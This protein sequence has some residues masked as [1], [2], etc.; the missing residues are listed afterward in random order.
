MERAVE[1][2]RQEHRAAEAATLRFE[3]DPGEQLQIDFG[4]KWI[5][6]G[7]ERVKAFVFVATLGYSR[8]TFARIYPAMRQQHWLE[9]LEAA[10]HHFGG[11]P[12]GVPG[13]Q[14]QGPGHPLERG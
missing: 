10:L 12:K 8:R 1:T 14:C 7:G 3:T 11:A 4:E 5:V 9:G 2:W 13:G 6:V